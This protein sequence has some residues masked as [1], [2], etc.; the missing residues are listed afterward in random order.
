MSKI[1]FQRGFTLIELL[2]VAALIIVLTAISFVSFQ[3]TSQKSR[4]GKRQADISQ[5][6][7]ALELY[8]TANQKYPIYSDA[9]GELNFVNLMNDTTFTPLLSTP[10]LIDPTNVAPYQYTYQSAAN[11]FTYSV[12]YTTEPTAVQTCLTNP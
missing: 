6:R 4:N 9:N 12:C 5:I 2:V 3:S 8:R 10:N 1:K 7:S 11:G